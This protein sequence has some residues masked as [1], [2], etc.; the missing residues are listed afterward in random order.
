M[1][2]SGAIRLGVTETECPDKVP[3]IYAT[4]LVAVQ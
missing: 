2:V 4:V 3:T 1:T